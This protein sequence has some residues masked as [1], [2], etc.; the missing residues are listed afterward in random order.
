[1]KRQRQNS[2]NSLRSE[3]S[4][5]FWA[6]EESTRPST[7]TST[8]TAVVTAE[9]VTTTTTTNTTATGVTLEDEE[10]LT[11]GL[12]EFFN[13][14]DRAHYRRVLAQAN[15]DK[16]A[17]AASEKAAKEASEKAAKEASEKV[18]STH[19]KKVN[20]S[21]GFKA[22]DG[23]TTNKAENSHK[24]VK[25]YVRSV[26]GGFG[27]TGEQVEVRAAIGA[28]LYLKKGSQERMATLLKLVKRHWG[29]QPDIT[30]DENELEEVPVKNKKPTTGEAAAVMEPEEGG[31]ASPTDEEDEEEEEEAEPGILFAPL[32][33]LNVL[34]SLAAGKVLYSQAIRIVLKLH[35]VVFVDQGQKDFGTQCGFFPRLLKNADKVGVVMCHN[36]HWFAGIADKNLK[37]LYVYDSDRHFKKEDRQTCVDGWCTWFQKLWEHR[38]TD[39]LKSGVEGQAKDSN[40][41]GIHTIR[42]IL[43]HMRCAGAPVYGRS[44]V[45]MTVKLQQAKEE[46][47]DVAKAALAAQVAA[48]KKPAA[49]AKKVTPKKAAPKRAAP[50]RA[51]K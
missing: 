20:H 19:H 15:A 22:P 36:E 11:G 31:S 34:P 51:S 2:E 14:A 40:D 42:N 26:W 50:K 38:V 28:A 8:T 12:F 23:T 7:P 29:V 33:A 45:K 27:K 37:K 24:V 32:R 35:Q 30:L 25:G 18:K 39:V 9:P 44:Q 4:D 16:A 6:D 21:V 3:V 41:G 46:E 43:Q 48:R 5:S 10:T 47:E 17:K 13:D 1:M 49:R